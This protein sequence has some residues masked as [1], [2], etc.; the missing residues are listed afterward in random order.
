MNSLEQ[1]LAKACENHQFE[2][3]FRQALLNSE[4][5]FLGEIDQEGSGEVELSA[6]SDVSVTYWLDDSGREFVPCFTSLDAM[7]GYVEEGEAYLSL[8]GR[9]F[10]ELTLGECVFLNPDSEQERW[11]NPNDVKQL[12][13]QQ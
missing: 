7:A 1:K 6:D 11:F 8:N 12:L 3:A 4:V 9:A 2:G 13:S 5:F 10:F